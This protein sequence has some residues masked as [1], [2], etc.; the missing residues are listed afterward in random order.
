YARELGIERVL[1]LGAQSTHAA[2]AC[3]AAAQHFADMASLLAAVREGLPAVGS[4]LIKGSRFMKMEQ[5]VQA[6]QACA[7]TNPSAA[8][9]AACC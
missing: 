5:V 6:V 9:E 7:G 3:G 2:A 1:T 4:L 8:S